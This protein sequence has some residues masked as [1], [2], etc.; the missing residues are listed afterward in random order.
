MSMFAP[1]P[2]TDP[3]AARLAADLADLLEDLLDRTVQGAAAPLREH[4]LTL[5]DARVLR[6]C[7]RELG[8]VH[9]DEISARSEL[10]TVLAGR[11]LARLSAERLVARE[12]GR[13][14]ATVAGREVARRIER[15]RRTALEDYVSQ[16]SPSSLR[17]LDAALHLLGDG[18][19]APPAREAAAPAPPAT[20]TSTQP[21][22]RTV[23]AP[24]PAART[25]PRRRLP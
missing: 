16:L 23:S 13:F 22:A 17:R 14:T 20:R 10:G 18:F 4:G 8:P 24:P 21:G 11:A 7:A 1:S 25:L 2:V 19:E 3:D 9:H 15:T 12:G 5:E 6:V